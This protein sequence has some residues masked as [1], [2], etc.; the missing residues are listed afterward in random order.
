MSFDF[1]E[2]TPEDAAWAAPVLLS[3]GHRICEYSFT[4]SYMWSG[5]YG[6][7]LARVG[8][9]PLLRSEH[10]GRYSYLPPVGEGAEELL[11]RLREEALAAGQPLLLHSVDEPTLTALKTWFPGRVHAEESPDDFDY[12][13]RTD[14]LATLPGKAYHSKKN[15][16]SAFTRAHNWT[17]EPLSA[18]N[19]DDILAVSKAWCEEKGGCSQSL[20]A[21]ACA[22]RR[23]LK[24]PE[25]FSLSGGL[26]RVDGAPVAFA[27]GS[28]ISDSVFDIHVEKALSAFSGAYAV[29]NREFAATLTQYA[30][31]NRE[32]DMGIEG[33]R[34][35][36][37]SYRPAEILKKYHCEVR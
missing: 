33:L 37:L 21:E 28:P 19:T 14:D 35:A 11:C 8:N 2:I 27:L 25:Q 15:H 13:Y 20:N 32:N 31:L 30:F 1:R 12:L 6:V 16:I 36:K 10:D 22:I 7:K 29:I 24:H 26:V 18:E 34:R 17:F 9:I 23:V 3:S 4:T 5:H